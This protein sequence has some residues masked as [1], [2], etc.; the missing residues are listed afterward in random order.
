VAAQTLGYKL[1]NVIKQY[2]WG[3]RE[4]I[5]NLLGCKSD[6]PWAELWM[7]VHPEGPSKAILPGGAVALAETPELK[8]K[9]FPFLLK[10]LAASSALSIQV[11]PNPR[12]ARAGFEKENAAGVKIDSPLRNY[13]DPNHKPEIICALSPFTAMVGF[14][15]KAEIRA[16]LRRFFLDHDNKIRAPG[17]RLVSAANR[18][19]RD[20]L[21][22][23]FNLPAGE[24]EQITSIALE[25]GG[26][27][28]CR[29]FAAAHPGDGAILSP[30]YLNVI[31][32]QPYEALFLP[33]GILHAY[34]E[35][36][37]IECM[38]N[39]DNVLRGGLSG[40]H[41]DTAEVLKITRFRQYRPGLLY[42]AE[43]NPFVFRYKTPAKEFTLYLIKKP[44][45]VFKPKAP[46]IITAAQGSVELKNDAG[47]SLALEQGESAYIPR[48]NGALYFSYGNKDA[49]LF[50]ALAI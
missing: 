2:S 30:L 29:R 4:Y 34:V 40:K 6:T 49:A 5:Q 23:L 43:Q 26:D 10:Y 14:R 44:A 35:G 46:A 50:A 47:A 1:E 31:H 36:F 39:S 11:H 19:C 21:C 42:G 32:L 33:P 16:L 13:R 7:G 12:Q 27:D 41:I 37:G 38:S 28:L 15:K 25:R 18:G 22:A 24:R 45:A 17:D 9:K 8:A 48:R 3:S 20:L